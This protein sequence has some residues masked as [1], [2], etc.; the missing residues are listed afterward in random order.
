MNSSSC[1]VAVDKSPGG[2]VV[3]CDV[4]VDKSPGGNVEILFQG[5][6]GEGEGAGGMGRVLAGGLLAAGTAGV[7]GAA[8]AAGVA[9][10]LAGGA[11]SD[12]VIPLN[13]DVITA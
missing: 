8:G 6:A 9:D 4:A 2:N 10:L 11:W 1:D 13:P 5:A 3:I 7:A 12:V